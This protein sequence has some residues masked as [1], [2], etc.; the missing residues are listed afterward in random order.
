MARYLKL[1]KHSD[2]YKRGIRFIDF[3]KTAKSKIKFLKKKP[4]ILK[5][6]KNWRVVEGFNR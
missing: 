2:G 3:G 1:K 4:K 5:K 6:Y